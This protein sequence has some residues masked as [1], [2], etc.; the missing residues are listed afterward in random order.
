METIRNFALTLVVGV[1]GLFTVIGVFGIVMTEVVDFLQVGRVYE[2]TQEAKRE[3]KFRKGVWVTNPHS[4]V[5]HRAFGEGCD[6][7]YKLRADRAAL[8][9][10]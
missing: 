8:R 5:P 4:F 7:D 10:N 1:L 6:I 9:A 2:R 3:C